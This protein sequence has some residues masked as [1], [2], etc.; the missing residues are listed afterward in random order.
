MDDKIK[1]KII[2]IVDDEAQTRAIIKHL[3][4]E[5][6]SRIE[7]KELPKAVGVQQP[8]INNLAEEIGKENIF[9]LQPR[10]PLPIL[11][12]KVMRDKKHK[13]KNWKPTRY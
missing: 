13:E 4:A 7:I 3:S 2:L 1:N 10:D 12:L 11:E 9:V 6:L 5:I 8:V